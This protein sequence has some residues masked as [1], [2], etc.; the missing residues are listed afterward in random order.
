[1]LIERTHYVQLLDKFRDK[2][3]I[4]VITGTRRCGKSTLLEMYGQ[5]LVGQGVGADRLHY[6]NLEDME[7]SDLTDAKR[8]HT[9]VL[10]QLKPGG[11]NYVFLDEV[12]KIPAFQEAVDSL[13][14]RRNVDLYITGSNAH[15]LSGELATLLSGRYIE[16][17]MLPL[18]FAEY[19]SFVAPASTAYTNRNRLFADYLRLSSYPYAV[20]NL[21]PDAQAVRIYLEGLYSTVVRKDVM[22]R[23]RQSDTMILESVVRFIFS[24]IGNLVSTLKIANTMSSDGRKISV[25]TVESYL[26]ALIDCYVLY[27]AKRYDIKGK[28]YLKT[29]DKYY[30]CDVGL[31]YNLLGNRDDDRG[32]IIE[33]VVYLELLRRGYD[34][35]IGKIGTR[36]IDFVAQ[37]GDATIYYQVAE[38]IR[39]PQ[40]LKREIAALDA[41]SDH[42]PKFLL[43]LDDDLPA[44]INGIMT[45]NLLDFLCT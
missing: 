34:V 24:N 41:I 45:Q 13:H 18:S 22:A 21:A 39:D 12:Q 37:K 31:R 28:Q 16:I 10:K 30:L 1:M 35:Y 38:T 20:V 15:L 23:K 19:L 44:N 8:L 36:E 11:M 9:Y 17:S 5:R 27:R 33:N 3:L 7:F 43:T 2:Q 32:H 25:H 6:I 14:L 42:H 29:N 4:K 40:T 26:Q